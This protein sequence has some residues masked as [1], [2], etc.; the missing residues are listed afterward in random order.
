MNLGAPQLGF[1]QYLL[2]RKHAEHW[3]LIQYKPEDRNHK[4]AGSPPLSHGQLRLWKP[5]VHGEDHP[6]GIPNLL[7]SKMK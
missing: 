5:Y 3:Q 7:L 4:I 6:L 1:S 2:G